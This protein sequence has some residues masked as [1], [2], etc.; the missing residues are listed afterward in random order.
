MIPLQTDRSSLTAR[1]LKSIMMLG[2]AQVA[3]IACSVLRVKLIALWLGPVGVGLN[4]ILVNGS[5]MVSTA[6]QFSIRDSSVRDMAQE[7]T[8]SAMALKVAV[9]RRWSLLL[10]LLGAVAMIALSPLLSAS[11]YNGSTD[12]SLYFAALAPCVFFA[13]YSAGEFAIM[14]AHDRMKSLAHANI[15]A[16]VAATVVTVPLLYYLRLRSIVVIIDIYAMAIAVCAHIWRVRTDVSLSVRPDMTTMWREGRSFLLLGMSISVSAMLTTLMNYIFAAYINNHGG[17]YD[18]GIY[19]SGYALVSNYVGV[20]FSAIGVEYYPRLARF[21]SRASTARVIMAH[22]LSLVVRLVA[23]VAVVFI[24]LSEF[25]VRL[26][27]SSQFEGIVPFVSFAIIGA[28]FRGVSMCYAYRILAAG[29]S[30]AYIFTETISVVFGLAVNMIG[31]RLWS[32]TGLG[33]SYIVWYVF[34]ALLTAGVCR[35]RYATVLPAKALMPIA[36]AVGACCA[37]LVLKY[38]FGWWMPLIT[39]LPML[40]AFVFKRKSRSA[41]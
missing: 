37:A 19:Q 6:T 38:Y 2:S 4:T 8:S 33:V 15:V 22:E 16:A 30:K 3:N 25:I 21:V 1:V 27:Y 18:L 39:V 23:P 35:Y 36:Y 13:A 17:E 32:Y 7:R 34:Y 14:Q 28:V 9:V 29:D 41:A 10:G 11:A 20:I 24:A 5:A 12:K 40:L 26:L 31:Y